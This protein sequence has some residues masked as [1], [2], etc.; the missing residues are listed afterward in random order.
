MLEAYDVKYFILRI[1]VIVQ[2]VIAATATAYSLLLFS[3]L[4]NVEFS[5]TFTATIGHLTENQTTV[6]QV[7]YSD[8]RTSITVKTH[9]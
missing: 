6:N 1:N 8:L 3:L 4:I 5:A 9:I 2:P 7:L